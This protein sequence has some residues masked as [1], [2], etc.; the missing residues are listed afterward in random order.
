[1]FRRLSAKSMRSWRVA[2]RLWPQCHVRLSRGS[3]SCGWQWT[4]RARAA[5][6]GLDRSGRARTIDAA[7]PN[8]RA[9]PGRR[10]P[11]ASKSIGTV[12]AHDRCSSR[13]CASRRGFLLGL[14]LG[15][16]ESKPAASVVV[17][18]R[19]NPLA[20]RRYRSGPGRRGV[21]PAAEGSRA[22]RGGGRRSR[23][24]EPRRRRR[25]GRRCFRSPGRDRAAHCRRAWRRWSR[26][27]RRKVL[28]RKG[29]VRASVRA[30]QDL[31]RHGS[32]NARCAGEGR[33]PKPPRNVTLPRAPE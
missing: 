2:L 8:A 21:A 11:R 32:R 20:L 31:T 5:L 13:V 30:K 16:A 18:P 15:N 28:A 14:D 26:A 12:A 4:R 24:G 29:G 1:M 33:S 3:Q 9:C 17:A 22:C 6:V 23:D 27:S 10:C 19:S 25:S 7:A